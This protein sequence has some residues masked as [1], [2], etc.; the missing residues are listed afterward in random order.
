VQINSNVVGEG[1]NAG[2]SGGLQSKV[3]A[4]IL[5]VED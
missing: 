1:V 5:G 3:A 2:E 4:I